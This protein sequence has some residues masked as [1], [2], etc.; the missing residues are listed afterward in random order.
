MAPGD[1]PD[2]NGLELWPGLRIDAVRCSSCG[3]QVSQRVIVPDVEG[4]KGLVIRAYVECPECVER[5]I[6]DERR[7]E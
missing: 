4:I 7:T 2:L 1:G 5:R 6:P 3:K